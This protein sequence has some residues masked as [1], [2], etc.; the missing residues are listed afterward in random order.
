MKR[1]FYPSIVIAALFSA[2]GSSPPPPAPVPTDLAGAH[3]RLLLLK[4]QGVGQG[5]DGKGALPAEIRT[6]LGGKNRS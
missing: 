3:A 4:E 2:A 1:L 6:A 5:Q